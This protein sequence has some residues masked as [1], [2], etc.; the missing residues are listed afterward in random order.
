MTLAAAVGDFRQHPGAIFYSGVWLWADSLSGDL[1][2]V[3]QLSSS[4]HNRGLIMGLRGHYWWSS[5][6]EPSRRTCRWYLGVTQVIWEG[7]V[8]ACGGIRVDA[9]MGRNGAAV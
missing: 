5:A 4:E 7:V 8:W 6:W 2:G 3:L 1:S 9:F